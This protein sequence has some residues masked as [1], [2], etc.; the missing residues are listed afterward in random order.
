MRSLP[1]APSARSSSIVSA[2]ALVLVA[3]PACH[4]QRTALAIVDVTPSFAYSDGD[5]GLIIDAPGIR[6]SLSID[7]DSQSATLDSA[8]VHISLVPS[9]DDGRPVVPLTVKWLRLGRFLARMTAGVA[10]GQ[11]DVKLVAP[12]GRSSTLPAA[13]VCGGARPAGPVITVASPSPAQMVG[14]DDPFEA[15]FTVD[16]HGGQLVDVSW[17][18]S[19]GAKGACPIEVDAETGNRSETFATA[20]SPDCVKIPTPK[21]SSFT[22]S[23]MDFV[24]T[25][26][27]IDISG[28]TSVF[29]TPLIIAQAPVITR[30]D[31][32]VGRLEGKQSFR[33]EGRYFPV[34]ATAAIGGVRIL[35]PDEGGT[36]GFRENENT[37]VGLV[38][39]SPRPDVLEV[40][41]TT[42]WGA[43]GTSAR[44][45][46]YILPPLIR[47]VQP[48]TG[49]AAGGIM[50]TIAGNDLRAPVAI[51]FGP[52]LEDAIDLVGPQYPADSKV[53]GTLPPG[54]GT[55]LV[56]AQDPITG[57][58]P[59]FSAFTYVEDASGPND[60]P[61]RAADAPDTLRSGTP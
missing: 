59:P 27:A 38:P 34:G 11:Y 26:T 35:N 31:K 24:L 53:V 20:S 10:A 16:D 3:A 43:V 58:G 33:V 18:T 46:N 36:G 42:P 22:S 15:S 19:E 12:D 56:W 25:V 6:P 13:F 23:T 55:V 45:F 54:H 5:L 57:L 29:P 47:V 51:K 17:F 7:L 1:R 4:D 50:M 60:A 30:I 39:P 61:P 37:I 21:S 2:L 41:V 9:V 32:E 28:Q 48:S 40:T 52:T 44:K 14:A 8:S 49:P